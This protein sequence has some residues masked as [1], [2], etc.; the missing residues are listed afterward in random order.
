MA[1]Y[2]QF[3]RRQSIRSCSR[4]VRRGGPQSC[5]LSDQ[6][7]PF[8]WL[9]M[10]TSLEQHFGHSSLTHSRLKLRD[11]TS[12]GVDVNGDWDRGEHKTQ[13]RPF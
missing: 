7:N 6:A 3:A 12:G 13:R 4:R 5:T 1:L 9:A 2:L 11:H 10:P 8:N